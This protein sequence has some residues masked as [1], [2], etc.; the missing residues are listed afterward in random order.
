[1]IYTIL[2]ADDHPI[3]RMGLKATIRKLPNYELLNEEVGDG[4]R[5][6]LMLNCRKPHIALLDF[7]MPKKNGL[8]VAQHISESYLP[9]QVILLSGFIT[10]AVYEEGRTLGVRGFL[11]KDAA[12][13]EIE[14]CLST[15]L[16]GNEFVSAALKCSLDREMIVE[17][18]NN[19]ENDLLL[20]K[21]TKREK[22][23]LSLIL[24][25]FS[26]LEIADRLC[27]SVHTI[28]THR[29]N[30]SRKFNVKGQGKLGSFVTKNKSFL[31]C[32]LRNM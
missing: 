22:K 3:T 28:E 30:I 14:T 12:Y 23:V 8:E 29:K 31:E 26:S 1:M 5:A 4:Q 9:T 7:D 10:R 25:G 19:M 15:V 17:R 20:G 32:A 2:H 11:L 13:Q 24:D 27:N 18:Q 16:N 21:L 6:I